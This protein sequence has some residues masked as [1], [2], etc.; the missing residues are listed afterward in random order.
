MGR[1]RG[2]TIFIDLHAQRKLPTPT[3]HELLMYSRGLRLRG[4]VASVIHEQKTHNVQIRRIIICLGNYLT[5]QLG[6][7]DMA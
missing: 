6:N 2:R 7:Q 3:D 1:S 4:L 5:E